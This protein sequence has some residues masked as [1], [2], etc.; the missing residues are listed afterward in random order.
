M[1]PEIQPPFGCFC[2]RNNSF[3]RVLVL[4]D[5]VMVFIARNVS[6]KAPDN[7]YKIPKCSKMTKKSSKAGM[8]RCDLYVFESLVMTYFNFSL[9][10]FMQ[11]RV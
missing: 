3:C 6:S 2:H 7:T 11:E 4:L 9:Y 1:Y 5:E 10:F 8:K